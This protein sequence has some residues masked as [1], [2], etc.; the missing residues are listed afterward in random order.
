MSIL[1]VYHVATPDT[2]NK[3]LTHADD[4]ASTLAEQGVGFE[5]WQASTRVE[6]GASAAEVTAAYQGQIDSWMTAEGY[7][8]VEVLSVNREHPQKDVV[9]ARF[10]DEYRHDADEIR[11]FAAGRGLLGLHIGDYVYTV[12]CEKHDLLRIPAGMPRWFD[13]GEE[14]R[15]V[16]ISLFKT[17][18]GA[19]AHVT[20]RDIAQAFPGLD[21]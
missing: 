2:P 11:L 19:V 4:I 9:A 5:R 1:F 17:A 14:P 21:D 20:G 3:V 18:S 16:A 6:A 12:L 15:V 8:Q 10:R 7:A 13:L